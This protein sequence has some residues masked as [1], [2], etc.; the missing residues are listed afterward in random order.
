MATPTT[1]SKANARLRA[2]RLVPP[3]IAALW[4]LGVARFRGW[5]MGAADYAVL[6][7]LMLALQAIRRRARPKDR[8]IDLDAVKSPAMVAALVGALAAVFALLFGGLFEALAPQE[9][10]LLT[11]WW[12]RTLWHGACAFGSSYCSFL[13]RIESQR[14]RQSR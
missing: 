6:L 11:P 3:F 12:L 7:A 1:G 8:P 10:P 5:P 2:L 14:L 9:A 4:V 13:A